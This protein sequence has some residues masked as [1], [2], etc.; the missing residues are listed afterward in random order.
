MELTLR[1]EN[2]T[3]PRLEYYPVNSPTLRTVIIGEFPFIIGRGETAQLQ[4]KSESISREHAQLI[5]TSTGYL[6]RDLNSTNG[7]SINGQSITEASLE[8]GDL[9]SIAETKLTFMCSA[10]GKLERM[11][12]QPLANRQKIDPEVEF[13]SELVTYRELNEAL[14]W[15]AIPLCCTRIVDY[16]SRREQSALVSV[17]EPLAA[18]LHATEAYDSCSSASRIQ[19]LAWQLAAEH[20][21]QISSSDSLLLH[22]ELHSG[23]DNRLCIALDQAFDRL[24]CHQSLGVVLPWEWA[25]QSPDSLALCAELRELG[26]ELAYESFSGGSTC[27]E[28]MKLASPDFLV[29]APALV[30]GISSNLRQQEQLKNVISNCENADIKV[31]LPMG[32]AEEDIQVGLDVGL[33]LIVSNPTAPIDVPSSNAVLATV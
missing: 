32:T 7:T 26:A 31:V 2:D 22:V 13:A 24:A 10:S 19:H 20:A 15:Q 9:V 1:K 4:I 14:L 30:R 23:F 16:Q 18:R 25:V 12:T 21:G 33:N 8:D 27:I 5:E 17:D 3:R 6:L 29:L 11:V 28:E